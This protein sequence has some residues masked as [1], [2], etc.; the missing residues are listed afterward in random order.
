[1]AILVQDHEYGHASMANLSQ[2]GAQLS[3]AFSV[4]SGD[5]LS[6]RLCLPFQAPSLEII[7]AAVR[8]VKGSDFGVE[9]IQVPESEHSRLGDFLGKHPTPTDPHK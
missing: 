2:T 5:R 1:M 9:F 3:S 8:W 6:L 7:S 4:Q